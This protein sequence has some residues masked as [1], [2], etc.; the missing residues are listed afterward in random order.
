VDP[1]AIPQQYS[2]P[3]QITDKDYSN[4]CI[5]I[6][7]TKNDAPPDFP[8]GIFGDREVWDPK[9]PR[10][11]S[12]EFFRRL[13]KIPEP[14]F[15]PGRWTHV[16]VTWDGINSPQTGHCRLYFNGVNEGEAGAIRERFNLDTSKATIRLGT[17][18]FAGMMMTS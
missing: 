9:N 6:D 2:D 18:P 1:E 10:G 17:G 13:L 7:F 5:W 11:A 15:G 12:E 8:V 14:P 3:F 4:D 16:A